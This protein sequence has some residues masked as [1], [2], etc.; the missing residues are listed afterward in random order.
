MSAAVRPTR[1]QA[2]AFAAALVAVLLWAS[3][4]VAMRFVDRGIDPGAL[5]L[6]R[7]GVGSGG[8]GVIVLG[9]GEVL[10]APGV[11]A[12][13]AVCGLLWFGIYNVVA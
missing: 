1:E 4:F 10:S 13:I 2:L 6:G 3:A 12:R 5:A 11:L 9:R 7:L 8:W